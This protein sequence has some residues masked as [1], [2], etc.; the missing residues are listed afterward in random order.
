MNRSRPLCIALLA[1]LL[2]TQ[3]PVAEALV[4]CGQKVRASGELREGSSIRL[5]TACRANEVVVD[6][7]VFGGAAGV[8][9][10]SFTSETTLSGTAT[11]FLT[12]D[13]RINS[14][15]YEARTPIGPGTL[16][17][18][19][20]YVTEA[21]GGGGIEVAA[22]AGSCGSA[23]SFTG[24]PAVTFS[25]TDVQVAKDSGAATMSVAAGQCVALRIDLLGTTTSAYV[26]CT[27]ERVPG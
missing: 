23:L 12:T 3:T 8:E 22:G 24:G 25:G 19:R 16:R 1:G 9:T 4:P 27:L 14:D 10:L 21:A 15:E 11:L 13:G 7:A 20:C 2:L 5:R 18:L 6:P 26:N 17:N